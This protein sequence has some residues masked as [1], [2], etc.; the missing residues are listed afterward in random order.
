M[1]DTRVDA[2]QRLDKALIAANR[3]NDPE[4]VHE[5]CAL[6][7]F[8]ARLGTI[9]HAARRQR[10]K[11][12]DLAI[13]MAGAIIRPLGVD[14][15]GR[16]YWRFPSCRGLFICN[17]PYGNEDEVA[18]NTSLKKIRANEHKQN[19]GGSRGRTIPGADLNTSPKAGESQLWKVV[20]GNANIRVLASHLGGSR[21]ETQLRRKLRSYFTELEERIVDASASAALAAAS[22]SSSS[23]TT[24]SWLTWCQRPET[25]TFVSGAMRFLNAL[26]SWTAE[27]A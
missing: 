19:G 14:D 22:A 5:V 7:M 9:R 13:C 2:V 25:T 12:A 17:G 15:M 21:N 27:A 8:R 3:A 4:V 26:A 23:P 20:I 24:A 1:V 18:F 6:E 11:V 16:E 10:V